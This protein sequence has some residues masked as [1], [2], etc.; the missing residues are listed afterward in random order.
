[1]KTSW[2]RGLAALI[3]ASSLVLGGGVAATASPLPT[4]VGTVAVSAAK[5]APAG[6]DQEDPDQDRQGRCQ[7]NHQAA[8]HKKKSTKVT[9]QVLTV[10]Q[11][12]KTIAKNKKS[13][14]LKAGKYRVTTTVKYTVLGK[15]ATKTLVKSQDLVVKTKTKPSWVYSN[16]SWKCPS[17]Y[18]IK[19]NASSMIYHVP[20]GAFYGRTNPEECF[21]SASAARAKGYRASKTLNKENEWRVGE[22]PGP[23]L[24]WKLNPRGFS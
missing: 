15:N 11:G 14:G 22:F 1:M 3:A 16:A 4:A 2:G 12:K 8:G 21:A 20:G 18:P 10:K 6:H 9:S 5:K 7:G 24:I 17:G 19:G 23:P 13:V